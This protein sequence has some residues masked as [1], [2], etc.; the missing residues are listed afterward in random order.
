MDISKWNNEDIEAIIERKKQQI[1]EWQKSIL[2]NEESLKQLKE[3]QIYRKYG[4][5][6]G[7]IIQVDNKIGVIRKMLSWRIRIQLIKKN[8]EVGGRTAYANYDE[9]EKL[10]DSYEDYQNALSKL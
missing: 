9:V 5:R 1:K 2:E 4:I 7:N 3:E 6:E 8:G 10:Y